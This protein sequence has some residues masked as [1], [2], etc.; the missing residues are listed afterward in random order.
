MSPETLASDL[1]KKGVQL[2][3]SVNGE[4]KYWPQS[5]VT[6]EE[7]Q[8]LKILKNETCG[9]LRGL[10][11]LR[12][13]KTFES[14]YTSYT[15][16]ELYPELNRI[17]GYEKSTKANPNFFDLIEITSQGWVNYLLK[18]FNGIDNYINSLPEVGQND[19]FKLFEYEWHYLF[20][21]LTRQTNFFKHDVELF[22]I[23]LFAILISKRI[24]IYIIFDKK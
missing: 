24:N 16:W 14:A 4:L 8:W 5:L 3:H 1:S 13:G 9:H 2:T 11:A 20:Q 21:E 15:I 7:R 10:G 6:P 18:R 19:A 23:E 22:L 17:G 12:D